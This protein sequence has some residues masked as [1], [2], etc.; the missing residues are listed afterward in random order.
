QLLDLLLVPRKPRKRLC[1]CWLCPAIDVLVR[2]L[3]SH[4]GKCSAHASLNAVLS[5]V[6]G[7]FDQYKLSIRRERTTIDCVRKCVPCK[8]LGQA[9]KRINHALMSTLGRLHR[10]VVN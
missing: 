10:E 5:M 6:E 7:C 8:L 1:D 3:Q 9:R 4:L 2:K